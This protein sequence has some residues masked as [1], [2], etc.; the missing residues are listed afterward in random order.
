M[1]TI[2]PYSDEHMIYS[3]NSGRYVLTMKAIQ[4]RFGTNLLEQAKNDAYAEISINEILDT[5]STHVY[6]FIYD[7]SIHN[8]FQRACIDH[9]ESARSLVYEA[10]LKQY[11]H[12]K[13]D[14]D[15]TQSTDPVKREMWFDISAEKILMR[16]LP[17]T[18]RSLL[19][20]GV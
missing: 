4:D 1:N 20:C 7:H 17:E 3:E 10:M 11:V 2:K 12:V 5:V 18:G 15:L 9:L 6:N 14:G 19:Y 13:A 16:V 8:D